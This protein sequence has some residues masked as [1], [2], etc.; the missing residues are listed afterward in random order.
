ML[1]VLYVLCSE[2]L[3]WTQPS[4]HF[5]D[6]LVNFQLPILAWEKFLCIEPRV[7]A[8]FFQAGVE[9]G[10]GVMVGVGMVIVIS[11]VNCNYSAMS[12]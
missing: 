7:Y 5:R 12:L 6:S 4:H 8:V 11:W 9:S 1:C 3:Q 10:R 2:F